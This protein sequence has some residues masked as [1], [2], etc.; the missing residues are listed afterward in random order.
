MRMSELVRESGVPLATVKYYL[1]EGLLMPGEPV[2]ATRA[3]YREAHLHRLRLIR[4]LAGI[5]LPIPR[6]RAV[7]RLIDASD[8]SS[9]ASEATGT[10]LLD[11]L[12]AAIAE[13]PPYVESDGGW[14][15]AEAALAELGRDCDPVE[16]AV[17][18][19]ER[20]LA[21]AEAVG[22][23]PSPEL[24]Q[25]YWTQVGELAR[26]EL[27]GMPRDPEAAIEYAV[28]GTALY[29]PVLAALRRLAYRD[30]AAEL[31]DDDASR[32]ERSDGECPDEPKGEQR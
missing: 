14:P 29:E 19:L 24:L 26:L 28:L 10:V 27:A 17:A 6:I 23:P 11:R 31:L 22:M 18:Q 4:A 16:P 20:A 2:S 30:L 3:E 15:R 32:G 8:G 13:L 1:R 7:L 21:A 25:G 9:G 5:G 12:G